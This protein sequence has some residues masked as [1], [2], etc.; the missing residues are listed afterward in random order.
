MS[1]S[2]RSELVDRAL[3]LDIW[4][5]AGKVEELAAGGEELSK[6]Q[7]ILRKFVLIAL[8]SGAVLSNGALIISTL[9]ERTHTGSNVSV[10]LYRHFVR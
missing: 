2:V 9:L 1:K 8:P 10:D 3:A 7:E 4:I 5:S 6:A